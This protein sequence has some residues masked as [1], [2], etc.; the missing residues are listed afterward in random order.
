MIWDRRQKAVVNGYG[1]RETSIMTWSWEANIQA[2]GSSVVGNST[3][4]LFPGSRETLPRPGSSC[5]AI[6]SLESLQFPGCPLE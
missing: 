1:R 5:L 2:L 3:G 6:V 4:W